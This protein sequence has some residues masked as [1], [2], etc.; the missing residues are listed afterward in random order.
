MPKNSPQDLQN[1]LDF[2]TK[3]NELMKQKGVRQIDLHNILGIPKSTI[4]G[5]IKGRSLPT[6]GNVQKLADFFGVKKSELDTRFLTVTP[7]NLLT[8]LND[9]ANQLTN[10]NQKKASAYISKLLTEQQSQ[11]IEE[12]PTLYDVDTVSRLAAGFGFGYN[13]SDIKT[14]QVANEPPRHDVASVVDGDSMLPDYKNGDIVYLVDKGF[15]RYSGQVC[16]VVVDDKTYLK[17]VYTE[18]N[19]LQLR[20]INP[21]YWEKDKF[22]DFPPAGDT[23][24]KIFTV[25]GSDKPI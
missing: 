16:A 23:H 17:R 5:Y 8:T 13:D 7:S 11:I 24:I 12:P 18:P 1:R 25:V 10:E 6:A 4:T 14:Y 19:G 9:Q 15:S 2:S 21:E 20:S 22:I 3:L